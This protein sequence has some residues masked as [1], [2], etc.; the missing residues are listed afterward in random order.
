MLLERRKIKQVGFGLFGDALAYHQFRSVGMEIPEGDFITR[1]LTN[2][3]VYSPDETT[4]LSFDNVGKS[5]NR[6]DFN[7]HLLDHARASGVK[8][9]G[10]TV[11]ISP[12]LEDG[13]VV[14]LEVKDPIPAL[15]PPP[16]IPN[17]RSALGVPSA[18]P[19]PGSQ[20]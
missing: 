10:S 5:I 3:T 20:Q 8:I 17:S 11:G 13:F 19:L 2:V 12:I 7:Q 9:V 16:S 15:V 18:F 1:D 14:G 4:S 6:Y